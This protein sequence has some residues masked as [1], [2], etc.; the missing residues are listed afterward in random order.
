MMRSRALPANF[1][2]THAL[3]SPF[4]AGSSTFNTLA[5]S[6]AHHAPSQ[7]PNRLRSP[8]IQ[9]PKP[10]KPYGQQNANSS[11]AVPHW[12]EAERTLQHS[13]TY[14]ATP[15]PLPGE[16][17]SQYSARDTMEKR[18]RDE[19]SQS[20]HGP[21]GIDQNLHGRFTIPR[22]EPASYLGGTGTS[23]PGSQV[24]PSDWYR[25]FSQGPA[26]SSFQPQHFSQGRVDTNTSSLV[27][28]VGAQ[29]K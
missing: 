23:V 4:I 29:C 18:V 3:Q 11:Y 22:Q 28:R 2:M 17:F 24:N 19:R 1:D 26:L 21:F 13:T 20:F 6:Q 15:V 14:A 5:P 9:A 16:L 8:S 25:G 7:N 10:S 12:N 27:D